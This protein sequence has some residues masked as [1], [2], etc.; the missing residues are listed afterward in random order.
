VC[1]DFITISAKQFA[2]LTTPE[3]TQFATQLEMTEHHELL[4]GFRQELANTK[5]EQQ[6]REATV[7]G[8]IR[9]FHPVIKPRLCIA[10]ETFAPI[11]A[12]S[13]DTGNLAKELQN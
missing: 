12:E 4:D 3:L 10:F 2:K 8:L 1:G 6:F 13:P 11:I 5:D 7:A 9:L